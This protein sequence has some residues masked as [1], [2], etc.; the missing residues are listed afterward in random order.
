MPENIVIMTVKRDNIC[1]FF[2]QYCPG[3]P[4]SK[5]T[6]IQSVQ[7]S[8]QRAHLKCP[9]KKVIDEIPFASFGNPDGLCGSLTIGSCHAPRTKTAVEKVQQL[10]EHN[11]KLKEQI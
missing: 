1:T 4:I 5:H 9:G 3:Q 10:S 2:S 6:Q 8:W 7:D 11:S